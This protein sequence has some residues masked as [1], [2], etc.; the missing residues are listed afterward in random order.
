MTTFV[1]EKMMIQRYV[2]VMSFRCLWIRY[3]ILT[4]VWLTVG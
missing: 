4:F 1:K 3:F 2:Y